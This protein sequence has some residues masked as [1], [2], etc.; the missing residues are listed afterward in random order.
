MLQYH[1]HG[2]M[3]VAL[4]ATGALA[5][6]T[7][8]L[9][10]WLRARL[11]TRGAVHLVY[12]GNRPGEV[13]EIGFDVGS[14]AWYRNARGTVIAQD[15]E[16]RVF[17]S[18]KPF[19]KP[20]R[21]SGKPGEVTD[22]IIEK[23]VP[24]VILFDLAERPSMAQKVIRTEDGGW[25]VTC[26]F[27][28]GQRSYTDKTFE[29]G[30][31]PDDRTLTYHIS[32]DARLEAIEWAEAKDVATQITY[33][34]KT[35]TPGV[36]VAQQLGANGDWRLV[37]AT[38][39]QSPREFALGAVVKRA[40]AKGLLN[41]ITQWSLSEDARDRSPSGDDQPAEIGLKGGATP[42]PSEQLAPPLQPMPA[43]PRPRAVNWAIVGAG[44]V[45]VGVGIYAWVRKR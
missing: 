5:Q 21:W 40:E 29:G 13:L 22:R 36:P 9:A 8:D 35:P 37:E 10:E 34:E 14:R 1:F 45:F 17:R 20:E 23:A 12:Q 11:P 16:G 7:G 25:E 27:P 30:Y 6:T 15:A 24:I 43:R 38:T 3:L 32:A 31:R 19:A 2:L 18:P 28:M 41:S 26:S 4:A 39:G 44:I 42:T 33:A